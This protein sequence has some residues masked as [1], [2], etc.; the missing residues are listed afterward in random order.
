MLVPVRVLVLLLVLLLVRH[1][2]WAR[3]GSLPHPLP[4]GSRA[5]GTATWTFS[6]R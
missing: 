1:R 6:A 3:R 5:A 2:R 4:G